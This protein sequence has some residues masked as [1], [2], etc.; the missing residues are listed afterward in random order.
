MVTAELSQ[1]L[2]FDTCIYIRTK[3]PLPLWRR[4]ITLLQGPSNP[5]NAAAVPKTNKCKQVVWRRATLRYVAA[6]SIPPQKRYIHLNLELHLL[7]E[8]TD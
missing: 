3:C 7:R 8:S 2:G 1:T 4:Y 6:F 5:R